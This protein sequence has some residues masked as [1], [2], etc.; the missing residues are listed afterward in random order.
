MLERVPDTNLFIVLKRLVAAT[1]YTYLEPDC[2]CSR[3]SFFDVIPP[4]CRY[5][6]ERLFNRYNE[7]DFYQSA[8]RTLTGQERCE[9]PC[10]VRDRRYQ[11][12]DVTFSE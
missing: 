11:S 2:L 9:C 6:V 7:E 8:I 5:Q 1:D 12:C 4:A 3:D 10:Y